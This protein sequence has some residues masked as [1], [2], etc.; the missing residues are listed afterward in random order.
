[1][2][3]KDVT[4]HE[5][6]EMADVE[7][8]PDDPAAAKAAAAAALSA[9]GVSQASTVF[10][11]QSIK[12]RQVIEHII[13]SVFCVAALYSLLIILSECIGCFV[14]I[15]VFTMMGIIVN[16]GALLKYV[17]LLILVVVY[18]YDSF[19]NVE[20]KYLKLNKAL[21]GEVKGRIKDLDKVTSLPS[22]LQENCGFK[23][24]EASEQAFYESADDIAKRPSRHWLIND[25]VL[26]VD[27]EDMPRIPRRLFDE[28]CE[29]R[30]AGVPGPVYRGLLLGVQQFLKI[31]FF[32]FFVFVVV[33]SFS[34]VYRVSTTNQMLA[35]LAGGFL[36]VILRQFMEPERPDVEIGT[37]SFKSKMD[38]VI[39]NFRQYWPIY[40]FAFEPIV[41]ETPTTVDEGKIIEGLAR[42]SS[43]PAV[44]RPSPVSGFSFS[45]VEAGSMINGRDPTG[46]PRSSSRIYP[47]IGPKIMHYNGADETDADEMEKKSLCKSEC[48][49]KE[50]RIEIPDDNGGLQKAIKVDLLIRLPPERN[51]QHWLDQWS[52]IVDFKTSGV[53]RNL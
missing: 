12:C 21:F 53:A 47:V 27:N 10:D 41:D 35:T 33:L 48:N 22:S 37:L 5:A 2:L 30:V 40:D 42:Q 34:E 20:K 29:I 24:Q 38:E 31:V 9:D 36:P 49:K 14:E 39:K 32:I 50:V 7:G 18:S 3:L 44:Q 28:V 45:D 11:R 26:F 1:M 17:S 13:A 15:F 19:N 43:P 6:L 51:D 4:D 8:I 52:D 25:L 46:S 16:A 23:A